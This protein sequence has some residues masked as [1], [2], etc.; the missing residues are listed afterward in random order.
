MECRSLLFPVSLLS[1]ALAS[2]GCAP[3]AAVRPPDQPSTTTSGEVGRKPEAVAKVAVP[4]APASTEAP[5]AEDKERDGQHDF[6]FLVGTWKTHHRRLRNP[7]TGSKTW[8][9][10]D[11]TVVGRMLWDGRVSE[12]EGV[13]H[14]PAGSF[15]GMTI[16]FYNP[17][18]HLWSLYWSSTTSGNLTLPATVGKFDKKNGRG[19]F[20]DHEAIKD[21]MV[22]VR[23]VWRDITPS[24]CHWEQAFSEDGGKT[25]ETNWTMDHERIK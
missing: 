5:A 16:R 24:S 15:D 3:P 9:E 13:I 14:D 23:Y 4:T 10:F 19:E 25:W 20:Y 7:L 2:A 8:V 22:L 1:L 18:T 12:D 17:K 21:K 11:G 6:D